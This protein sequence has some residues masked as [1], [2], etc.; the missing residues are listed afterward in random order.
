MD[1][2]K[3]VLQDLLRL[4]QSL[5]RISPLFLLPLCLI[6]LCLVIVLLERKN[7]TL[8]TW[9]E[10]TELLEQKAISSHRLKAMQQQLWQ[11]V[12]KSHP[13]YLSQV[14]EALPLLIPEL[15]RV[16]ALARQYPENR[17][18]QERL[19][20]LQSDKNRIR[21]TQEAQREGPF[22][23][24]TEI[25]MQNTVQMNEDDLRKFLYAIEEQEDR[26]LLLVKDFDLKKIKEKA[27]E[28]VFT[29]QVE[30]IKRAP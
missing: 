18:L 2:T 26:P 13:H 30:L 19:F 25:K 28:T 21:F 5:R 23:Q 11:R 7:G 24:E 12:Q 1:R 9:T 3:R 8:K 22:F 10:Q 20:Y 6:P 14:I 16:Q 17:A 27:D 4:T 29:V 15:R